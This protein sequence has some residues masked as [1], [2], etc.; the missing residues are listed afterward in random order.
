MMP[1]YAPTNVGPRAG[2]DASTG[3][4]MKQRFSAQRR[5]VISIPAEAGVQVTNLGLVGPSPARHIGPLG[6]NKDDS[7]LLPL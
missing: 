4:K 5:M 7:P 6:G 3:S 2:V 1:L